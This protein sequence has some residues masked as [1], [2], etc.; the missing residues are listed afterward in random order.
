MIYN[1]SIELDRQSSRERLEWFITNNKR[2]ELTEKR[3]GRSLN[4]NAYLHLILGWFGLEY[5]Y[6]LEE[7]KTE[8]FKK[9]VNPDIFYQGQKDGPLQIESWR[10]SAALSSKEM[11]LAIDRFRDFSANHGFYLPAP[12]DLVSLEQIQRDLS[13]NSSKQYL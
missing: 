4:Q 9:A 3:S 2:F 8:I 6:T 1:A 13:K 12:G 7:V 5:G 10:T 11:T